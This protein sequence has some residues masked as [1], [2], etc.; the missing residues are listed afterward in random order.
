MK[1]RQL[2]YFVSLAQTG[3]FSEAAERVHVSQPALSQQIKKLEEEL[4]SDLLERMGKEVKLTEQGK[5]FLPEAMNVLDSVRSASQSV[6]GQDTIEGALRLGIIPTIAPYFLPTMME[7]LGVD[8]NGLDIHIEEQQTEVLINRLKTGSVDHLLL[9]PPIPTEGLTVETVGKEPF[10]LAVS[11]DDPLSQQSAVSVPEMNNEPML[12][13]EEGH[14]LRDQSLEFCQQ[15]DINPQVVFQGS[16]LQSIL[17][18]VAT[19]F[20]YTF[21]P[22]MVV[23]HQIWDNV[24]FVPVESPRPTRELILVRR[25]STTLTE[26]DNLFMETVRRVID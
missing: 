20:G 3:T 4:E 9:S 11:R 2:E 24:T 16:S 22:E 19:D 12:L 10:Y 14:C 25:S 21:V 18:L 13:L 15:E 6:N 5:Q 17:N 23:D 7:S 8:P 26:L 1:L